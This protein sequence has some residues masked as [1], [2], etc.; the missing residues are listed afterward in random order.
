MEL[1]FQCIRLKPILTFF[2]IVLALIPDHASGQGCSDAGFCTVD[3][4]K[5]SAKLDTHPP[6]FHLLKAGLTYGNASHAVHILTPYLEYR[7]NLALG[8]HT[9]TRLLL[10]ARQGELGTVSGAS[11]LITS[12]G[13]KFRNGLS[14]MAGI[15]IPFGN[16]DVK[17]GGQSLPMAYQ[18]TLGT[19]DAIAGLGY[20]TENFSFSAAWQ[21]PLNNNRN[22][23][24]NPDYPTSME[25]G[26]YLTTRGY[27]RRGDL[28]L[29]AVYD[30]PIK[31]SLSSLSGGIMPIYHL[32]KDTYL[33]A[34]G[35]RQSI[36]GSEGLTLNLI[37]FYSRQ[38]GR[39]QF[40]ELSAG[41]PA[42]ARKVRPDGLSRLGIG[43][44]YSIRL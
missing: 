37:L 42:L 40:L 19:T 24:V 10:S 44:E 7:L 20:S 9:T 43:V 11:D 31:S 35:K 17:R 39:N 27:G 36:D 41:A 21:Q 16:A 14:L 29:R 8:F 4:I 15:K 18:I 28:L 23:F 34:G 32:G 3:G 6:G 33:D 26:S 13:Y 22:S 12:V 38:I 1:T 25:G 30:L 2:S 5:V